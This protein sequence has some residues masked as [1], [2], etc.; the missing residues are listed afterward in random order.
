MQ[1]ISYITTPT[2]NPP[3]ESG[4]LVGRERSIPNL[5][6]TM[7]NRTIIGLLA[8]AWAMPLAWAH[9]SFAAEYDANRPVTLKGS[10]AKMDW[11]NPHSWVYLDVMN[12]DGTMQRWACETAPP[13]GLYRRGW[14]KSSLKDGDIITVEGFLA[15]DGSKTVNARSVV[16]A[17]GKRMFAGSSNDGGP[18]DTKE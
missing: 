1:L 17:D 14:R 10:F 12:A 3:L 7:T 2:S 11:V 9:H 6:P 8:A 4:K 15:K 5:E 13:N 16:T 18:A